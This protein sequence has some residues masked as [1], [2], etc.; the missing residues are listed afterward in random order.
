VSEVVERG[1]V[2]ASIQGAPTSGGDNGSTNGPPPSDAGSGGTTSPPSL[3]EAL[4]PEIE[5]AVAEVRDMADEA[6]PAGP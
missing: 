5:N 4:P 3:L 6:V 1:A 2:V